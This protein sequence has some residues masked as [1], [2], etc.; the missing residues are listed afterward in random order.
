MNEIIILH[1]DCTQ[2]KL[3][4]SKLFCG[5]FTLIE[6]GTF[7]LSWLVSKKMD[8]FSIFTALKGS[9]A[10]RWRALWC[11]FPR[12]VRPP[13]WR[14]YWEVFIFLKCTAIALL[15][16]KIWYTGFMWKIFPHFLGAVWQPLPTENFV[17]FCVLVMCNHTT[18]SWQSLVHML[19]G[20]KSTRLWGPFGRP[21]GLPP[22]EMFGLTS[23]LLM[24]WMV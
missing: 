2:R 16:V 15:S 12:S 21:W 3:H 7:E 6:W 22:A 9:K 14:K 8:L 1:I 5:N 13:S 4:Y 10:Y 11:F 17:S 23:I 20:V 19:D 18:S 24:R